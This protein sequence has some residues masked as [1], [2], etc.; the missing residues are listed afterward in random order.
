MVNSLQFVIFMDEWKV[1]LPPNASTTIKTVRTVALAEFIDKKM[2]KQKAFDFYGLN[3]TQP[4]A[5]FRRLEVAQAVQGARSDRI[6]ISAFIILMVLTLLVVAIFLTFKSQY[7]D[8]LIK[9]L[10]DLKNSIFWNGI[11]RFYL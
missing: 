2:V 6:V 8:K 11:I 9:A 1:N 5:T 3:Q 4:D 10:M 7:K